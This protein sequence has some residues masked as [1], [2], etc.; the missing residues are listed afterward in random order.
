MYQLRLGC[1]P[2]LHKVKLG[3]VKNYFKVTCHIFFIWYLLVGLDT[4]LRIS[5]IVGLLYLIFK[6][7]KEVDRCNAVV[8]INDDLWSLWK[9]F[10]HDGNKRNWYLP[11]SIWY[12]LR[13]QTTL[14]QVLFQAILCAGLYPNVAATEKGIAGVALG[15]L[16]QSAGL[17]TKGHQ[18]WYDGRR[19][20][21][22]HP[23]S[24]NSSLKEFQHPFLVFL[25]K[26]SSLLSL[27][28]DAVSRF[29]HTNLHF[30]KLS[31]FLTC[32]LISQNLCIMSEVL[33]HFIF[34][35]AFEDI[36]SDTYSYEIHIIID[37]CLI[38]YFDDNFTLL[39]SQVETNKVFLRDTTIVSPYSILLFGGSIN[40]HHQ[41]SP[42]LSSASFLFYFFIFPRN[43]MYA[44]ILHMLCYFTHLSNFSRSLFDIL[45]MFLDITDRCCHYWWMVKT[46]GTSPNCSLVQETQIDSSF[47]FE[48]V[49]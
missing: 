39:Y 43:K 44:L 31:I 15:T 36:V 7:C 49:D 30:F 28:L 45:F 24:I 22:I 23:S 1:F 26:V 9:K 10:V 18:V 33:K 38:V 3:W 14:P 17:A 32:A 37:F 19:E 5:F 46:D 2:C 16:K 12:E 4:K 40:V 13:F 35:H 42:C 47:Y 21:H 6:P 11:C 34:T 20:V 41:V 27:E 8:T 29:Y 25:E 48:G